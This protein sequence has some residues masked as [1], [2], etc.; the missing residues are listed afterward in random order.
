MRVRGTLGRQSIYVF[1]AVLGASSALAG[2]C[3]PRSV[4]QSPAR[5]GTIPSMIEPTRCDG[6]STIEVPGT[7]NIFG[8]GIG[9]PPAPAGGGGGSAPPCVSFSSTVTTIS[10]RANGRVDF[11]TRNEDDDVHF[12]RC[13]GGPP[14]VIALPEGPDGETTWSCAASPEA[15][16]FAPKPLSIPAVG[17][18]SGISSAD[19]GGYLIGVF[20]ADT[21]PIGPPPETLDFTG[22][23]D[24]ASL[25]P[26]LAQTFFVGDG[27]TATGRQQRFHPPPGATRLYLGVGDAWN[28]EGPP[29]FYADNSGSFKVTVR[30]R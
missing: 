27:R 10:I 22:K 30:F 18:I 28:F 5:S 9:D 26:E 21:V 19:G 2:A 25:S 20:L 23:R 4:P 16:S 12:H 29:G 14:Q 24:F 15:T 7:S 6:A 3:S 17:P 13:V 1:L 11:L 8:A